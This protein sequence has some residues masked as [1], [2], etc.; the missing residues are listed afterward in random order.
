VRTLPKLAVRALGLF[1][2]MLR[3]LGEMSD[4]FDEPFVL[5]TTKYEST[6]GNDATP[7]ATAITATVGWYR[8][9]NGAPTRPPERPQP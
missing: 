7:L 1:N 8:A 9:R 3:E 5:D 6:F 4:Q 2:P